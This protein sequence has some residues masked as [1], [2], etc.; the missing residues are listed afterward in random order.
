MR[1]S[2]RFL[3]PNHILIRNH[4]ADID[5]EA[6]YQT[7]TLNHVCVDASYG[8]KQSQKGI[9]STGDLLVIIDMND[10]AAFEGIK[11]RVFTVPSEFEQLDNTE[12]C[13]TL[14]PNV[15]FIVYKGHEYTVN[16]VG[17]INPVSDEPDFLEIT[18]NE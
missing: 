14:R 5:G 4:T 17:E 12:N 16:T 2:P 7:T 18:A 11:K 1:R 13:F 8:I 15:D 9:Q 6:K 3:R 10:L